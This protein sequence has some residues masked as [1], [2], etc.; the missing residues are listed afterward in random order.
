MLFLG[1]LF[2]VYRAGVWLQVKKI[3]GGSGG[4]S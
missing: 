2:L 1:I 3:S 4:Q